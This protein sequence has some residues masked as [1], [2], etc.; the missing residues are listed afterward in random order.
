MTDQH[1]PVRPEV[2]SA[3]PWY[4]PLPEIHSLGNGLT[5]W[6]YHLP[7]QYVLSMELVLDIALGDEPDGRDGLATMALNCS[8][9]GSES[10]PGFE[11]ACRIED[12]GAAYDGSANWW[13]THAS[14]SV[15]A[16]YAQQGLE[17]LRE[18]VREPQ[19]ADA[20]VARHQAIRRAEVDRARISSPALAAAALREAMW[21]AGSRQFLSAGG[22]AADVAALSPQDVRDFH[23][24]WWRPEGATLVLAGDLPSG[25][26]EAACKLFGRWPATGLSPT[27]VAPVAAHGPSAVQLVDRP[28]A[29]AADLRIGM[30]TPGR[31][32]EAWVPLQVA[33]MA[34]G[35]LFSSRLNMALREDRGFT[36]GVQAGLT[37]GRFNGNFSLRSSFRTEV[38]AQACREAV[39]LLDI[40]G[41]PLSEAEAGAAIRYLVG[42]APLRYDTADA[43]ANQAAVLAAHHIEPGWVNDFH[44]R[45]AATTPSDASA[46]FETI[47][48]NAV[49][50]QEAR[51]ALCGD[52]ETLLPALEAEGFDVQ[53]TA[54]T[55]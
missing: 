26:V 53:V 38:A 10:H 24:I 15:A 55:M 34:V 45:I 28:G 21:P 20:D 43:I 6:A 18:I 54:P 30:V 35:G 8:D 22:T 49:H 52:A 14:L 33:A 17:L 42:I 25:L 2:R 19:Y 3:T 1:V 9:E 5:V 41:K 48:S 36:Y 37:A 16:P 44:A 50:R 11:M 13:A 23:R 29:V 47:V 51:M 4:F 39:E 12:I 31:R 7:G 27:R 40:A 32:D 46:A